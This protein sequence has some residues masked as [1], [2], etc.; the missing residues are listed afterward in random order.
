MTERLIEIIGREAALFERFLELLEQQQEMLIS[1]DIDG[2]RLVSETIREKVVENRL[3][4]QQREEAVAEIKSR[5]AI[6]GDLNVTRLLEIVDQQQA[7]RLLHLRNTIYA[8]HDKI[9]ET[10]NRNALLINRS[11]EY[12]A[13]TMDMLSQIGNPEANYAADG[14]GAK[15][16]RAVAIDR[17]A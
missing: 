1:D 15:E 10:R 14:G 8:L 2:L 9:T 12:I 4:N 3:L 11:R 5:N 17:S 6:K 13:R 16:H 7:D